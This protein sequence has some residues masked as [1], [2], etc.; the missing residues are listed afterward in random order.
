MKIEVP[1]RLSGKEKKA[2]QKLVEQLHDN[3]FEETARMKKQAD[4]FYERKKKL[5]SDG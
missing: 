3:H 2:M 5:E 4:K 1:A